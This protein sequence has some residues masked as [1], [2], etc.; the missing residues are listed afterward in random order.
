[1]LAWGCSG[2]RGNQ[3]GGPFKK[4]FSEPSLTVNWVLPIS[5]KWLAGSSHGYC[6]LSSLGASNPEP[7]CT[8]A[9]MEQ[10]IP[11]LLGT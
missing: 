5:D 10:F 7:F 11:F 1:M 2:Y 4:I 3:L 9:W 8:P 6:S